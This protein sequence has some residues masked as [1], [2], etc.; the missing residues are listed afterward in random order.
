MF[1][2]LD[3][4]LPEYF[5]VTEQNISYEQ[6]E[7]GSQ[8]RMSSECGKGSNLFMWGQSLYI[9]SQLLYEG[10]L[11]INELDPIKRFLPSY[12]R[13][14]KGGRYSAFQVIAYLHQKYVHLKIMGY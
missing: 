9:I 6:S 5:Y 1:L 3:P 10:L 14:R 7:P 4:V 8:P 13:P 11:H 12:N 2:I